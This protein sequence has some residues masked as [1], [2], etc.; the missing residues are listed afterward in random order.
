MNRLQP[1][2]FGA[3][4]AVS[5]ALLYVACAFAV[6]LAPDAT[7]AFFNNWFHGIDLALIVPPGGRP[8]TFAQFVAGL[9]A[10]V[11]VSFGAGAVIAACYNALGRRAAT[12]D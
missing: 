9:L 2:R 8:L 11:V 1:A 3:A 10:A 12:P 5:F 6:A 4:L 7:V